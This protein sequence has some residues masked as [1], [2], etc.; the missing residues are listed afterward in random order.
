MREYWV[1]EDSRTGSVFGPGHGEVIKGYIPRT[2]GEKIIGRKTK[3]GECV[4][5]TKEETEAMRQHPEFRTQL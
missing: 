2:V 1:I 4:W 5:F 3:K